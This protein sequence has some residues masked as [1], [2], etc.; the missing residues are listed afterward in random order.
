M[1][2]TEFKHVRPE[3]R[4]A[5]AFKV[6]GMVLLCILSLGTV[7]A[8]THYRPRL[9]I[10]GRAGY[11]MGRMDFSP[12]VPQKWAG[13]PEALV[14]F[15]YQEEKIF[16]LL[17]EFGFSTR[18]WSEDFEEAPLNFTRR[19]TYLR[20]P[21]MTHINFGT[22]RF[23]F[24]INLGPE[25]SYMISESTSANFD[26][27]NITA[28]PDFPTKPRMTEQMGMK[29]KNKFDYGIA[30]GLGGEYLL[31]PRHS[32]SLEARFYFGLGNVFP[33]AKTDTFSASRCM[34]LEFSAGYFFRLK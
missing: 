8:E 4:K 1:D 6:L 14:S 5:A 21:L 9:Y 24:F 20:L 22:R 26:Y 19:F 27:N 18:G 17:A 30:L 3:G 10:G 11:S 29:V 34:S 7:S 25:F 28:V 15:R 2:H 13:G 31:K 16:G 23:K 32:V 12:S 33:S